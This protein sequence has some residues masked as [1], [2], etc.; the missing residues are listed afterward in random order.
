MRAKRKWPASV[1]A[2][3]ERLAHE[4]G[5]DEAS[6]RTDVP[7]PTIRSWLSRSAKR[8]AQL[9]ERTELEAAAAEVEAEL[10]VELEMPDHLDDLS[11]IEW[12]ERNLRA[13]NAKVTIAL[14]AGRATDAK[15]YA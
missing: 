1:R 2:E 10:Q 8:E 3:A 13:A 15:N 11:L 9:A 14:A 6:R 7:A 12:M 4:Y 5:A